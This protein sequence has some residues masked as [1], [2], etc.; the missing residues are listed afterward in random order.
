MTSPQKLNEASPTGASPHSIRN[1]PRVVNVS[2]RGLRRLLDAALAYG[3]NLIAIDRQ[4]HGF[5]LV[6]LIATLIFSSIRISSG[7]PSPRLP[8]AASTIA[9]TLPASARIPAPDTFGSYIIYRDRIAVLL[10][11]KSKI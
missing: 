3:A 7:F 1:L 9:T 11:G 2:L 10:A 5:A 8:V 6:P 4:F